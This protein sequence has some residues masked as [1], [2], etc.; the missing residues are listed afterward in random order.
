MQP[1]QQSPQPA[2]Q[3]TA[4]AQ[5]AAVLAVLLSHAPR[6]AELGATAERLCPTDPSGGVLQLQRLGEAIAQDIAA[7]LG[8]V[9]ADG[10]TQVDL[11]RVLDARMALDVQVAQ[12]FHLLR[13]TGN[14]AAHAST[15]A[16]PHE[17]AHQ[18]GEREAQEAL[19]AARA[20]ARW[21]AHSVGPD[22]AGTAPPPQDLPA[23]AS[24]AARQIEINEATT[25]LII[26]LQL[27]EAG[28]EADTVRLTHAGGTRPERGRHLAIS[29]WPTVGRQSA[30]YVL[31]AGLVP[32]AIVEAKRQG[33]NVAG[34]IGQAERYAAG[35]PVVAPLQPAWTVE[36]RETPWPDGRPGGPAGEE[37]PGEFRV[38]F[39]YASNSRP[40]VPQAA[41]I[42]G[43]WF[44]DARQPSNTARPLPGFHSPEGLLDLLRR[45]RDEA[46]Q[47]LRDEPFGYLRLRPY[48]TDA[49]RA[50]E[51]ALE[52]GH[53]R[54]LLAMATGT[55]KTRTIIGLIYR[56][57][58]TERFRR[59]LFLVDRTAL[60]QQALDAFHEAPLEQNQTLSSLYDIAELGD[61]AAAAETRV[62]VATVQ[63]MVRRVYGGEALPPVDTFDC[64]IV[65]EAHRG[66]ALD[67]E[68][69]E[70]E[71]AMRD[72]AQ[73]LS[74]YRR[75]LEH[76]DAVRIGLTATPAQHTSEIFGRPV[77]TY[78]YR[79]AVADDW[80]ID[81][82][83]PIRYETELSRHG[84][85]FERG[86]RVERLDLNT[87]EI[88]AAELADDLDFQVEHFN[89]Q[90]ISEGFDRVIC[91]QLAQELDPF[92]QQKTLIFCT[93]DAHADRVKRL[94]DEAFAAQLGEHYN[95]AAVR[96][97]T[98]AVDQ[99]DRLIRRFKNEALPSIAI[100]VDLLS[101]GIDVPAICHLVFLRRVKSRILYEQMIGRAT[102]RCDEI[103]KTVFTIHDPVDLYA[104]LQDV[105]TM[106]PLVKDPAVSVAQLAA[107]LLDPASRTLP[108][109]APERSHA[110][111]VL[112]Q[113]GQ[114]LMRTL[115]RA[116]HL[117]AQHD[118]RG[119]RLRERLDAL[120]A[121][122]QVEPAR[123]HQHL[124]QAG[125]EAAAD[126]LRRHPR[127]TE[128]I[129]EIR[130]LCGQ[131][132][133]PL[134][135]TQTDALLVREQSWGRHARPED[136]LDS[137]GRFV[138]ERLNDSVAL[139]VTV[140]RP[141][142]LTREQLREVR[143]LLD[144]NGYSEA[145][146]AAAWRE[147]SHQEIAASIVG[148]IR[149]AA[150]GEALLPFDQRVTQ[151]MAR[152][153]ALRAW[154]PA[155]RK[156]L[157]RLAKQLVHEVV[158]DTEVVNRAFADHG[159]S[160]GLDR[161]LGGELAPVMATLAEGLWPQAA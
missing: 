50:V 70:G 29:E 137:F 30:D 142:D 22:S 69:T 160:R 61:Q 133:G 109:D 63:A 64:I 107:E 97:I 121:Q 119:Q 138:R 82:E 77:F 108:G 48:Q 34:R 7:R 87:G 13:R 135:S 79:E 139:A 67:Q 104:A 146:L 46:E 6:L 59:I 25:R 57:L 140:N 58:K 8:L 17:N 28:W 126:F 37:P 117:A 110:D 95:E 105:S 3:A 106:K 116:E 60:G 74:S 45:R 32:V 92:G 44:R 15:H 47:R 10:C 148:H 62:Q 12:L 111:M 88:D 71:M 72:L 11:L 9:V 96:K 41:E 42:S 120:G 150:L 65:D 102:R 49:I 158:I 157:D 93:T 141:R 94:L 136:Y 143:L 73:Y 75:V 68:M 91:E 54:C 86:E 114:K 118:A 20:L 131:S 151:A 90:V 80:L 39:V 147:K 155:Q 1:P 18:I 145:S 56:L 21:H 153:H 85:H 78:S 66:Y 2:T 84:I 83:P 26:D 100:T 112:D 154:T 36:G 52:A 38:P 156:W 101:T 98:G 33:V 23:R 128:Q 89:R 113:L 124:H 5:D 149:R 132:Y 129:D 4:P 115:R 123:L 159:G 55:G 40:L 161:Q 127:L 81:H 35:M 134:I 31:F 152:V 144:A 27:I 16:T 130:V 51:R 99:V 76:F 43:T 53:R 122:W 14:A 24:A 103:G 125:V 19:Q